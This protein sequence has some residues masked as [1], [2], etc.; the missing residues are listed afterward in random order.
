MILRGYKMEFKEQAAEKYASD[1]A[2]AA[3]KNIVLP[4]TVQQ[5][6]CTSANN[7]KIMIPIYEGDYADYPRWK[8]AFRT[9]MEADGK[10]KPVSF[11]FQNNISV[12]ER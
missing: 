10:S 9:A 7:I 5:P 2:T 6:V 3:A 4:Q 1:V 11:K 12:V 8:V